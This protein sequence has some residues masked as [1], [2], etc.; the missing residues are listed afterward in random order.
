MVKTKAKKKAKNKN[1]KTHAIICILILSR[2][3]T[4]V[5]DMA[6]PSP[7]AAA[8]CHDEEDFSVVVPPP[9]DACS[10]L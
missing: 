3:A 2:G 10:P 5:L 8:E 6:A 1:K 7:P 9:V 4:A